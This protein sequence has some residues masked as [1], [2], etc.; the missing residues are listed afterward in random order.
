MQLA[1]DIETLARHLEGERSRLR[2]SLA[3]V[4]KWVDENVKT[5]SALAGQRSGEQRPGTGSQ[6]SGH[7]TGTARPQSATT[8]AAAEPANGGATAAVGATPMR[9]TGAVRPAAGAG[10]LPL[11]A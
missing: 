3:E 5:A 8:G 2:T 6:P 9:P 1:G 4:I 7:P 10:S 11:Q